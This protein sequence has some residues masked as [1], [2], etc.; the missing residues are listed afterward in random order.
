MRLRA[1][2]VCPIHRS[3]SCCGRERLPKLRLIR[4]ECS[5]SKIRI[6]RVDIASCGH[7]ARCE[8]C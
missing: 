7:R 4:L 8:S 3:V 5:G 1:N 6:I 2:E